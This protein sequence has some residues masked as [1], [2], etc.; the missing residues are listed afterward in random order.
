MKGN[1]AGVAERL[2]ET[3]E[4]GEGQ[5]ETQ[6]QLQTAYLKLKNLTRPDGSLVTLS[7]QELGLLHKML[8]APEQFREEQVFLIADFLDEDEALDHVAAF[9][10]AKDLGMDTSFNVAFMFALAASNRKGGKSNRVAMLLDAL[11][12]QKFTSNVKNKKGD[13]YVSPASPLS[14]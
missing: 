4:M 12:H 8:T 1:G 14:G 5:E 7:R 3:A 10:E 2:E 9:Y 11:S 13:G 6:E